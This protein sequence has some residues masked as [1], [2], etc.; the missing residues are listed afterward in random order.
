M[1]ATQNFSALFE[2]NGWFVASESLKQQRQISFKS[3]V[4]GVSYC[5]TFGGKAT[6][7][8]IQELCLMSDEQHTGFILL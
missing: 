4:L 1:T 2:N 5:W 8:I 7:K 3:S 6:L